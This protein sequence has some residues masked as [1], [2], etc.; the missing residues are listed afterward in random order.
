MDYVSIVALIILILLIAI[1]VDVFCVC[2]E[3]C[4]N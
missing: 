3:I 4:E 2:D 1:V